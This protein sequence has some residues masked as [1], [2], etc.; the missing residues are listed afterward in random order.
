MSFRIVRVI[1]GGFLRFI[2]RMKIYGKENMPKEGAVIIA[3]N[4]RSNWDGPVAATTLPR[5]LA[6]MGKKELFDIP[7]FAPILRWAGVFPVARGK[8]DIG[9]VKA[10]LTALKSGK[11]FAIF[12]EGTRVNEN[13][14]HSAKAGVAMIAEKTGAPI[15]P[16]AISGKYRLFSSVKINIDKPIYVKSNNGEKLSGEELQEISNYLIQKIRYLAGYGDAPVKETD[17]WTFE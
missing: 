16:V 10:A 8:N 12:P 14:E 4:H 17:T 1:I 9:A 11:A 5:Q 7:L 15:V 3:M 13:Q 2:F 6:I